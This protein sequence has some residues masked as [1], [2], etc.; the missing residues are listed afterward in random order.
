M[1]GQKLVRTLSFFCRRT[2]STSRLR[3]PL[4]RGKNRLNAE[5]RSIG[6]Q[7]CLGSQL[8]RSNKR[9]NMIIAHN[10]SD[11]SYTS[12]SASPRISVAK[13]AAALL[14]PERKRHCS[15]LAVLRPIHS[16]Q[17]G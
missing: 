1:H 2:E 9:L 16:A 4:V 5:H 13:H 8:G 3:V 17:E 11:K 6:F 12:V 14:L 7:L 10:G 15:S